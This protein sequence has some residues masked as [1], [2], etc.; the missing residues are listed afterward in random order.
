MDT[1]FQNRVLQA[2]RARQD[3]SD[4]N[5]IAILNLMIQ[6]LDQTQVPTTGPQRSEV[7]Q[8]FVRYWGGI[9]RL[10]QRPLKLTAMTCSV[11]GASGLGV[12]LSRSGTRGESMR[13]SKSGIRYKD[14][15]FRT[16]QSALPIPKVRAESRSLSEDADEREAMF[17]LLDL[18]N[19]YW[20]VYPA[21]QEPGMD[22]AEFEFTGDSPNH[23]AVRHW[24]D[25]TFLGKKAAMERLIDRRIREERLYDLNREDRM[26]QCEYDQKFLLDLIQK[27]GIALN[28]QT[29]S[30]ALSWPRSAF[31]EWKNGADP[32]RGARD[33][34]RN[35]IQYELLDRNGFFREELCEVYS[36]PRER[37]QVVSR[38]ADAYFNTPRH[39]FVPPRLSQHAYQNHAVPVLF[40]QTISQPLLMSL[41]LSVLHLDPG[42]KVLEVGAGSGFLAAWIAELVGTSGTVDTIERIE[43][44][45]YHAR[46]TVTDDDRCGRKNVNVVFEDGTHG[47]PGRRD[48]YDAIVVS[49]GAP[50]LSEEL[51]YQL[52]PN[53]GRM[54]IP[55]ARDVHLPYEGCDLTFIIRRGNDFET[56]KIIGSLFVPLLPGTAQARPSATNRS[57]IRTVIGGVDYRAALE[58][59]LRYKIFE[60]NE[61]A[62]LLD[63]LELLLEKKGKEFNL[64]P[65]PHKIKIYRLASLLGI[66]DR[67]KAFGIDEDQFSF[68]PGA[69][70]SR[71]TDINTKISRGYEVPLSEIRAEGSR[72][73]VLEALLQENP[74]AVKIVK[75]TLAVGGRLRGVKLIQQGTWTELTTADYHN[76]LDSE[77]FRVVPNH[78]N[79]LSLMGGNGSPLMQIAPL[80]VDSRLVLLD[81]NVANVQIAIEQFDQ[82]HGANTYEIKLADVRSRFDGIAYPDDTFDLVFMVGDSEFGLSFD[83]LEQ[84]MEEVLRVLKKQRGKFLIESSNLNRYVAVLKSLYEKQ[85]LPVYVEVY[86]Y[87]SDVAV[88]VTRGDMLIPATARSEMRTGQVRTSEPGIQI[89]DHPSRTL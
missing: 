44:L 43:T 65:D 12:L 55:V 21:G 51:K 89:E 84:M 32:F 69:R 6:E 20:W 63:E 59:F 70:I 83:D 29:V 60:Q 3:G 40:G 82:T 18:I 45:A 72:E 53:G 2:L 16:P 71:A 34:F 74:E 9:S 15:V 26:P 46:R 86:K 78:A 19:S 88:I 85:R 76:I 39:L 1:E 31:D 66:W 58:N 27:L 81:A 4:E 14:Q 33:G 79:V 68:T 50:V 8:A 5:Q 52:S 13:I 62:Q 38:V 24:D 22:K 56:K 80:F 77:T 61:L 28:P 47:Y 36:D 75:D 25:A 23:D 11:A 30:D 57:E 67:L 54:V 49:A 48:Y 37:E 7:R 73:A 64:L 42:Q 10:S 17:V 87:S 41:I 35:R